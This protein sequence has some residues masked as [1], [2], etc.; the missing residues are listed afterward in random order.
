MASSSPSVELAEVGDSH[1]S[2]KH[3]VEQAEERQA[4]ASPQPSSVRSSN[5]SVGVTSVGK[6]QASLRRQPSG[7]RLNVVER[8][9]ALRRVMA[10]MFF[11]V[12]VLKVH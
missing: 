7:R 1:G 4:L 6:G 10:A 2:Y 11:H 3:N 9:R 5:G 12:M 8:K